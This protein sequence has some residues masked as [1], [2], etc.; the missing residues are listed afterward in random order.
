MTAAL[1]R[2]RQPGLIIAKG[3]DNLDEDEM[4]R[5]A[6]YLTRQLTARLRIT[7]FNYRGG[8]T[9][10]IQRALSDERAEA[11]ARAMIRR[12]RERGGTL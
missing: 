9:L 3:L 6:L 1:S 8:G 5:V 7:G 4:V 2:P 10:P 11:S 12:I